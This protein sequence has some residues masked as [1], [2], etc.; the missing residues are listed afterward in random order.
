M[1]LDIVKTLLESSEEDNQKIAYNMIK[2]FIKNP[3][4]LTTVSDL[5]NIVEEYNTKKHSGYKRKSYLMVEKAL[6]KN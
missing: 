5:W 2:G 4:D 1:N 6:Y 3:K